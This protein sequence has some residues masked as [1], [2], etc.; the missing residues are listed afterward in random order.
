MTH[1]YL[2]RQTQGLDVGKVKA[3]CKDM[4]VILN[5][6]G[7]LQVRP[8]TPLN[9]DLHNTEA[10]CK[11]EKGPPPESVQRRYLLINYL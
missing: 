9:L 7:S 3:I 6:D 11:R 5:M 10:G 2:A 8:A 4:I 1:L